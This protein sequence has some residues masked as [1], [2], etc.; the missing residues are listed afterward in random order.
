[1]PSRTPPRSAFTRSELDLIDRLRTPRQVQRWLRRLPYNWGRDGNSQRSFRTVVETGE[2]HC[3]EAVMFAA[4]VLDQ[5]GYP[6]LV[7]D[8]ESQDG[9]DHVLFLFQEGGRWGTVARSRD[10]GLHGRAPV[11]G[12]IP[13]LVR[14]YFDP[15]VD[16][17]GRIV[18][19]GT[20]QL[21]ELVHVDWRLSRRNLWAVEQALIAMRH[22]RIRMSDRRYRSMLRR[23]MA[24]KTRTGKRPGAGAMRALY[25]A[26]I[27]RWW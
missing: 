23:Y 21:D 3:L 5:H 6:P 11:F 25:G 14:S 26:Q 18:R 12:D 17:S 15:Y 2:A 16:G 8:I 13:S 19:W 1:M 4:T 9:L 24:Q 22:T 10:W 7:L 20:A 27:D